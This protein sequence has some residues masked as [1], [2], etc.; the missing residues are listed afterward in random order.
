M[1]DKLSEKV[2]FVFYIAVLVLIIAIAVSVGLIFTEQSKPKSFYNTGVADDAYISMANQNP[3]AQLFLK[4][5]PEASAYVDRSGRLAVDYRIDRE[6]DPNTSHYLRLRVFIDPRTNDTGDIFLECFNGD[7]TFNDAPEK[8][9][10]YLER[11]FQDQDKHNMSEDATGFK[12][13]S[14]DYWYLYDYRYKVEST[15]GGPVSAE[16]NRSKNL[17]SRLRSGDMVIFYSGF[18]SV[19]SETDAV[20]TLGIGWRDLNVGRI[21][22]ILNLTLKINCL[23]P[24]TDFEEISPNVRHAVLRSEVCVP[25]EKMLY[26]VQDERVKEQTGI[27]GPMPPPKFT[28][29][30]PVECKN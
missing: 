12:G 4:R 27:E 23:R 22:E 10:Y 29:D 7:R 3:T 6:I 1:K 24:C 30:K 9:E 19:L 15:V 26:I 20:E 28:E 21:E 11:C 17:S 2:K 16:V 13:V 18:A 8:I 14:E 25:I 5:Y